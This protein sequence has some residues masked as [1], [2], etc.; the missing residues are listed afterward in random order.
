[1]THAINHGAEKTGFA[2]DYE[3][4]EFPILIYHSNDTSFIQ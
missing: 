4:P 1:M 2:G 3:L